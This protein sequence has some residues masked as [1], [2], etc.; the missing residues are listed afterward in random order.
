MLDAS[1]GLA[2]PLGKA[3]LDLKTGFDPYLEDEAT[4]WLVHW[5]LASNSSRAT[6]FYWFFN[7]FHKLEFTQDELLTALKDWVKANV[8]AKVAISTLKSDASL[9]PRMYSSARAIGRLSLEDALD[10]PLAELKLLSGSSSGR[11]YQS[12]LMSRP[13]LP[14]EIL[15]YA[16]LETMQERGVK[17][18]PI[19][20]LMYSRNDFSAPGAVFRLT[21]SDLVAKLETLVGMSNGALEIRDS[22]GIHQLY[23]EGELEPNAW[24]TK[25]YSECNQ[26]AAA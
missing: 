17:I 6:S 4:L 8:S 15:G 22:G 25:Y 2:T 1:T 21:E 13:G 18:L 11:T 14:V 24:L 3:I 16:I 9:L 20:E 12:R 19:E 7:K 5:L 26:E 23:F 10:N